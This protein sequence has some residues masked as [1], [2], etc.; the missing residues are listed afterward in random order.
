MIRSCRAINN[1]LNAYLD[2][3]LTTEQARE[4]EEHLAECAR[5]RAELERLRAA[6]SLLRS[7]PHPTPP[8]ELADAI[9][10]AA[11]DELAGQAP[12]LL[13]PAWTTP[14]AAAAAV[15]VAITVIYML[16][17]PR[18]APTDELAVAPA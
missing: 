14:L 2:G 3:E 6:R 11:A 15:V 4:C 13:W 12:G 1:L 8:P 7:L 17:A 10:L 9:K 5:C 18:L 16:Q